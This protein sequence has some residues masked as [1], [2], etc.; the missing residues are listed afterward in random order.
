LSY[1][2]KTSPL[3]MDVSRSALRYQEI[4]LLYPRSTKL[5]LYLHKYFI[6]VVSLCCY[7]FK[8]G[9]KSTVQQFAS[10]LSGAYL[11]T[12]QMDLDKWT[13]SI[14]EQMDVSE[15]QESSGFRVLTRNMVTSASHQQRHTTKMRV[16]DFCSTYNHETSWKQIRKVGNA[17]FQIQQTEYQE[18]RDGS[19]Q[20][21][22]QPQPPH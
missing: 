3:F 8:F 19:G 11:K 10:S 12:F 9:Q 4:A 1:I 16:L 14:K 20:H 22:G 21:R 18:W 5:Q 17:L 2:E 6:V 13:S 15:T 7:L